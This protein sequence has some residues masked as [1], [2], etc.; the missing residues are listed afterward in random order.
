MTTTGTE[1]SADYIQEIR[2]ALE[3]MADAIREQEGGTE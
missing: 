1:A 3:A 2:E